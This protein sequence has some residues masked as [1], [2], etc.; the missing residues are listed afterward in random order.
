M[1]I[2][3]IDTSTNFFS[4]G[5]YDNGKIYEYNLEVLTRLSSLLTP[6]IK[7]VL[8]ALG[9]RVKDMDYFACG[10]GPGSFTGIR[11]GLSAIKG[12]S[13]SLNKPVVGI[14]SLDILAKNIFFDKR[15]VVTAVDAKRNLIY[16]SAFET[17]NNNFKRIKPYMLLTINEFCKKIADNSIIT[18]DALSLHKEVI[19]KSLKGVTILDKDYWYPKGHN[20]I[21]LALD[22]IRDKELDNPFDVKPIYL[23]PKECQIRKC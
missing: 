10:I 18:G 17:K 7:R 19:I 9:W 23:Y 11:L 2:L 22:R 5:I 15:P 14:S 4:L 20:I 1:K 6:T 12:L 3:G 8:D 13:W 16:C 21:S